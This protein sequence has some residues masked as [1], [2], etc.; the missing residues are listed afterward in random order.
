MIK[1]S[2]CPFEIIG[3]ANGKIINLYFNE[4]K[5]TR[6]T[7]IRTAFEKFHSDK[8]YM[9]IKFHL[10]DF[11]LDEIETLEDLQ[12]RILSYQLEIVACEI[13]YR[14]YPFLPYQIQSFGRENLKKLAADIPYKF[15]T[16]HYFAKVMDYHGVKMTS[17]E[18]LEEWICFVMLNIINSGIKNPQINILDETRQVLLT[19]RLDCIEFHPE[20]FAEFTGEGNDRR[21]CFG[22]VTCPLYPKDFWRYSEDIVVVLSRMKDF[23]SLE[24]KDRKK[25]RQ[26]CNSIYQQH[27]VPIE[28]IFDDKQPNGLWIP[29]MI[30]ASKRFV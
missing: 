18:K 24:I 11:V 2:R 1:D 3:E 27:G 13:E 10:P 22:I 14:L 6:L 26:K 12:K 15:F 17:F 5:E 19:M 29:E 25:I 16:A 28:N 9:S 7:L 21:N 4:D 30:S 8:T 20:N 23:T